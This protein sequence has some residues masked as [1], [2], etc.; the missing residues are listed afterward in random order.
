MKQVLSV[1]RTNLRHGENPYQKCAICGRRDM[2]EQPFWL[3]VA[4][5][6]DK[7]ACYRC[8]S[9]RE[10]E[11][12]TAAINLNSKLATP[13]ESVEN[14]EARTRRKVQSDAGLH[15]HDIGEQVWPPK[16]WED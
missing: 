14:A 13:G 15:T 1:T 9:D 6:T 7:P 11:L 10:P 12:T 4:G 2:V 3:F 5:D 16:R 8:A